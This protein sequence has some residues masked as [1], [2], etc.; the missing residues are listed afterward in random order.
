MEAWP[1]TDFIQVYGLTELGG[2]IT[3][4]MPDAHREA[5]SGRH[6]ERLVS[7]GQPIPL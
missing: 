3:H 1:E 4:L 5:L 6:P 2:V 7:A